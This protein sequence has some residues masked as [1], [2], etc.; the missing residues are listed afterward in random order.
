MT[1]VLAIGTLVTGAAFTVVR[2]GEDRYA[3]Q[4]MDRYA[5]DLAAAVSDRASDYSATVRYL[6]AAVGAQSELRS[7]DYARI[8]AGLDPAELPG[9]ASASFVVPVATPRIAAVQATWRSRGAAGLTL[10]ASPSRSQH[11]FVIYERPLDGLATIPGTDVM[12]SP[13]VEQTLDRAWIGHKLM[14]SSAY[15]LIRDQTLPDR[16]RQASIAFAEPIYT[17]QGPAL[18]DRFVGWV[19][20]PVRGQDFLAETLRQRGQGAV[21]ATVAETTGDRTIITSTRSGRRLADDSLA[22]HRTLFVGQR[23]WELTL[24]PTT[25]LRAATDRGTS[26][27]TLGAG[28]ALTLVLG[29][30]TGVLAGSRGRAL[31]QVEHATAALRR[32]ID[33]R[34]RV[35]GQLR[36]SEQQLRHL[37]FHDPLTGLANRALF[38]DRLTQALAARALID[39][40]IAVLFI[41]LD[42]FKQV[43]DQLGHQAGDHVLRAVAERLRVGLRNSDTVARLGGDEFAVIL[44]DLTDTEARRAAERIIIVIQEPVEVDGMGAQ[45]SASIGIALGHPDVTA[46]HLVRE[47]DAAMYFA[48]LSGKNQY[49]E[50]DPSPEP[51]S[52]I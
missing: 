15:H 11:A 3:A 35:E 50:A 48:K 22:R 52:S 51:T 19:V 14:V 45:V 2:Q 6:A 40:P 21:Q 38:Y 41:D 37:A 28:A 33:R 42:G 12:Q 47:A 23:R 7:E 24:W 17:P 1:A 30:M 32:D 20:M 16:Q 36:E 4:L 9:V 44:D 18:P 8:T 46:D 25:S 49:A 39:R 5:A 29:V 13:A 27:F 31:Q 34:E 43:N 10:R 26:L